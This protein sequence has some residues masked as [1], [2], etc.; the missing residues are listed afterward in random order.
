MY[1]ND[2]LNYESS[3]EDEDN[4]WEFMGRANNISYNLVWIGQEWQ[5]KIIENT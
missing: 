1:Q 2:I 3:S 5:L 4:W